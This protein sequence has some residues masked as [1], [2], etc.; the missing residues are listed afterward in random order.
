MQEEFLKFLKEYENKIIELHK[1]SSLA[2][3]N[4]SISGKAE[5]YEKASELQ[6]KVDKIFADKEKF[7]LLKK[8]KESNTVEDSV[9]KRQLDLIY[10]S[11]AG[12]QF[13]EEL[14]EKT[15]KLANKV[16]KDFSTFRAKAEG[17]E[18][19]DNQIDEI[20][21]TETDNAKLKSVWEASK[22]IGDVVAPDVIK[23]VKMRNEAAREIGYNNYHEMSLLLSEQDPKEMDRLFDELD[24]MTKKEFAKLKNEIDEFLSQKYNVP[25]DELMPW[26]YQ[27]KFF[28]HG[29]S[30]YKIEF[31][32][33]FKEK[34][35]VEITKNYYNGI[36]LEITDL[37]EKSDLFEKDG[38]YQHAYCIPID[39]DGDVR[40]LCNIKPNYRWMSTM[41]HEYGHA[42]Y[43]KYV[44]PKLPW[45]LRSHAHIFTTEA[46]AMMFG[47]LAS[48]P[49]WLRDVIGISEDEKHNITADSFNT[50]RL[51]QLV[52][53]RWEQVMYRFERAMYA[54]SDQD[55]NELWWEIVEKYQLI[56]KPEGRNNADWAAKIHLA[57]YP[58][59]YHNY[60]LGELLASQLYHYIVVKVLKEDELFLQSF[61]GKKD[62]GEY[63][64][65]L[66]FSYGA[67]YPWNELVEKATGEKL[68]PKFYAD[69]F[70]T[71]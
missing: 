42:V 60:M 63:L 41:L 30:I 45:E 61:A 11:F 8:I 65:H 68:T 14:L 21:Q 66:F 62:V 10:N 64:K 9:L 22:Q 25:I 69:Q 40:V 31:D 4:A 56:K 37:V 36:S 12:N 46:I 5:D 57:L 20:L 38:K 54:D 44:S 23:L 52:F 2:Y 29:P 15:V 27:D 33:Y 70:I 6:L 18:L 39:R 16:E 47:R 71:K 55:L 48:N 32:D 17:E 51:E 59:Y 53:T 7:A 34:D 3:F 13:N 24:E 28:Q 19:T 67:L 35:I 49:Q 50:L 1:Q 26:H 43:D 58:A